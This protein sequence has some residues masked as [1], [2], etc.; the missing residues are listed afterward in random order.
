MT[1]NI[2]L[3]VALTNVASVVL[4]L[5][6]TVQHYAVGEQTDEADAGASLGG[7]QLLALMRSPRW[8]LGTV[9]GGL[10]AGIQ[11]VALLLAP[12]TVVQP[13]GILAVPWTV[14][15]A[16][17]IHRHTITPAMW[18]AVGLTV[19][20]TVW[21]AVV[22]I[23]HAADHEQLDDTRLISGTLITFAVAGVLALAGVRGPL[24][25]RS[26]AWSSAGAVIYGLESGM[27]TALGAATATRD[28]RASATFWTLAG[29]LVIGFLLAIVFGQ[30]GYA[31]GPA[32]IVVGAINAVNPVAAVAFGILVLGEGANITGSAGA[33]MVAA[34]AI[35]LYGVVL[36]SR[37]HPTSD[38]EAVTRNG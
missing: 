23:A 14:M 15:L 34:A 38:D 26:L 13:I 16:T 35:A 28:W 31:T 36:L 32:E 18:T 10:G 1:Q 37:F 8:W 30:Q 33:M 22:A 29:R 4:A 25:W 20:G 3:A 24:A 6:A 17:R 21:F 19:A 2:P 12:V 11:V 7:R 27:V 5:A 9:L